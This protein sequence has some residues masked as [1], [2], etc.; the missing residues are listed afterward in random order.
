[1]PSDPDELPSKPLMRSGSVRARPVR[2]GVRTRIETRWVPRELSEPLAIWSV[3]DRAG[4]R[5]GAVAVAACGG[6]GRLHE[7]HRQHLTAR[8]AA[9]ALGGGFVHVDATL[10]LTR[11]AVGEWLCLKER[12]VTAAHGVSVAEMLLFDEAG[13]LGAAQQARLPQ[14]VR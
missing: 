12:S 4:G 6:A 5:R 7:R 11:S 9:P 13:L 2:P 1:M 8:S 3:A 14:R 10:Y